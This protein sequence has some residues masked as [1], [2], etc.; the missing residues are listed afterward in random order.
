[1]LSEKQ[2]KLIELLISDEHTITEA[3]AKVQ[4][5]KTT[6]Y[7]WRKGQSK[8][9]K[10]FNKAYE[11]ALEFKVRE[12]RK[13]IQQDVNSLLNELK[14]ISTSSKN[15][16][17]RV[18]AIKQLITYAELDPDFKQ[19]LTIN[20]GEEENKNKLLEMLKAKQEEKEGQ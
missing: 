13:N 17:A 14:K 11:E 18:Q 16:N 2:L 10:E 19:Q 7:E 15:D 12:S 4:V 9:G 8:P 6:F 3:L 1:M 5:A 20:N